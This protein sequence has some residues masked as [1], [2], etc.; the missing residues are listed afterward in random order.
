MG[1]AALLASTALPG[2]AQDQVISWIYCGDTLD[3]VHIK[4]I[5]EWEAA[6]EGWK[7]EPEL[8]GWLLTAETLVPEF[9]QLFKRL[10]AQ[11][12]EFWDEVAKPKAA[13]R[14]ALA[15]E[16]FDTTASLLKTLDRVSA[17]LAAA[18]NHQ[19]ATIDQLLAIKQTA[20]LL[21]NTAGEA[22]LLIS[23]G[24]AAGP[25]SATAKG[26]LAGGAGAK[27]SWGSKIP[28]LLFMGV[29]LC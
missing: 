10:T 9:D 14:A 21:R 8:V 2:L 6:N 3:P 28:R 15:Q 18:V 25:S 19:D 23:K 24:L 12:K 4:Y 20:W 5:A 11:Q 22:S 27:P 16:Y 7:V 26:L 1:A 29:G 13:R 17:A